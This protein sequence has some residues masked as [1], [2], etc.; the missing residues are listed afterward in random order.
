[1]SGS[2][3]PASYTASVNGGGSQTIDANGSVT[4]SGLTAGSHTVTLSGVPGNCS[5]SGGTSH[6][7][8]VPAGGTGSTSFTITCQALTGDLTVNTSTS[9]P[10]QPAS[11]TVSVS[12]GSSQTINATGGV[13]FTGLAA[14]SRTVTIDWGDGR[15]DTFGASEGSIGGTHS[16]PVTLLGGDYTLT[17]TVVD[18]HGA[19]SSASKTVHVVV[20]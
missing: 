12:G 15:S 11:Y 7:A 19:R 18:A 13:T 2:D 10:N 4:F 3:Q 5:V 20:A 14:G 17:I 8:T 6:S 16:Y 9:G 1:T